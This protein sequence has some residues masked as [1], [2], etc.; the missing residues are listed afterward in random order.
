MSWNVW[1]SVSEGRASP[2]S[3]VSA[4][5]IGGG[6]FALFV[7][8]PSGGVF[9][10][11]GNAENGW[12]GWSSVSQGQAAIGSSVT[13]VAIG[14]GRFA[15]F[16]GDPSGGIFT[17]S[18]NAENGWAGWSSVSQG[19]AAPG[20]SV[21]AVMIEGGRFALFVADALGGV[22]TTSGNAESGWD[23]WTSVSEGKTAPGSSVTAVAIGEDKCALFLADPAGGVFITSGDSSSPIK[24]VFVLML[25]NRS[26]DH[27]LGF[28]GITGIDALTGKLTTID[29]LTGNETNSFTD[30][31]G[32]VHTR[33]VDTGAADV[34]DIGPGHEFVDVLEQLCGSGVKYPNGGPY[35]TI[36][37]LGYVSSYANT[38]ANEIKSRKAQVAIEP[39]F[40]MRQ[41]RLAALDKLALE[42]DPGDVM[43]CFSQSQLP[44]LNALAREFV[45]CDHWFSSMPGPTEPNRYFMHAATCGT[46]DESPTRGEIL[47]ALELRG[48]DFEFKHGTVFKQLKKAG[49]KYRIY[50]DDDHPVVAELDGVSYDDIREFEDFKKDL[51]DPSFDAGFVHIEPSYDAL[52]HFEDGNSQH[53]NGSVAAG[54]RFIKDTYEAIRSSPEVWDKSLLIITWDE[55][56]GFY[57]HVPPGPAKPTGERGRKHGF[58]FDQLGP[59]VPAV[60]VSPLIRGNLIEH[61]TFDHT[62]I[63]ATLC[64]VFKLPSLGARDGINGGVDHLV[65]LAFRSET[66]PTLPDVATAGVAAFASTRPSTKTAARRPAALLSDDPYGNLAALLHSAVVQ[67]LQ[68]APAEQRAAIL[69]RVRLLTTHADAFAYLREVEQLVREK[70][71]RAG[72]AHA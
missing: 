70:R 26:F 56:G 3:S 61:R 63:I 49:V 12:A 59:R 6:R 58:M 22:F 33:K 71:V 27:M 65:G 20:S 52:D 13:A 55:H 66:P 25:E 17:N 64:R 45:V 62:A 28:S 10:N 53:P 7:G 2:G 14:G 36:D 1:S 50:A 32:V 51:K 68:V 42:L 54:E 72:V 34:M 44:V 29:G 39:D 40:A 46:F 21:T 24:H 5:P 31:A 60:I 23:L 38:V 8:D 47:L 11:S 69:A 67:H 16:V 37:N 30:S 35:P 15:L 41:L 4:V 18:G 19:K 43:K 9:T 48:S 57:D